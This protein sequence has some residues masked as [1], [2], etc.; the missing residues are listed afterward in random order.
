[1]WLRSFITFDYSDDFWLCQ[2][3]FHESGNI[4]KNTNRFDGGDGVATG[5]GW[6]RAVIA[7]RGEG[8]QAIVGR[9][10]GV[11]FKNP[12]RPVAPGSASPGDDGAAPF[13][14][15]ANAIS[16]A[17]IASRHVLIAAARSARCAWAEVR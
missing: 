5:G 3:F 9:R 10:R 12:L 13:G 14:P 4:L 1:M 11:L 2:S 6:R 7:K 15:T 8:V 16:A 17:T